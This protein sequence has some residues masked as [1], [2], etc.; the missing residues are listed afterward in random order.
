MMNICPAPWSK[1]PP[2]R[3]SSEV[4]GACCGVAGL[5][6]DRA[7]PQLPQNQRAERLEFKASPCSGS[8]PCPGACVRLGNYRVLC[9]IC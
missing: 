5:H 2:L 3:G 7:E 6:R 8:S 4:R 9:I 1:E